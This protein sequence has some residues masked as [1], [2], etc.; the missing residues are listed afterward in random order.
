MFDQS[1]RFAVLIA[2]LAG[3]GFASAQTP[4]APTSGDG[5]TTNTA[6]QIKTLSNLVWLQYQAAGYATSGRYYKLMNDIDASPTAAW[7][8]AGTT[9]ALIEGF[10][11]IGTGMQ[12]FHGVFLGNN[13]KIS[14]L[15]INRPSENS[16]GVFGSV[17]K[18][19]RVTNLSV[20]GGSFVGLASVGPVAGYNSGYMSGCIGAAPVK[21]SGSPAGLVGCNDGTIVQCHA[22]GA[23]TG[24]DNGGGL[25]GFATPKSRILDSYATGAVNADYASGGLVGVNLGFISNCHATGAVHAGNRIG[26][27][28]GYQSGTVY[29]SYATGDVTGTNGETGGLFGVDWGST[30]T[31]CYSTGKVVGTYAVGGLIGNEYGFGRNVI[32]KCWSSGR[33]VGIGAVGGLIGVT[34]NSTIS[35]CYATGEVTGDAGSTGTG[36]LVGDNNTSSTISQC[37]ATG[38][39]SGGHGVGGL[40]GINMHNVKQCYSAGKVSGTAELGG[41]IGN[42]WMGSVTECYWDAEA[43]G[44]ATSSGGTGVIGKTTAQMRQQATF[45]NW[46]FKSMW[47]VQNAYPYLRGLTRHTLSYMASMN[48]KVGDGATTG[49]ELA[50]IV[51]AG[52]A[53]LPVK[54][55]ADRDF[56]FDSWDDGSKL[57][58]RVDSNVRGNLIVWARFK[59]TK[60]A[61]REWLVYR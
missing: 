27:L 19:A 25:V 31:L 45:A 20:I 37:Y 14:G 10:R 5:N 18:G 40:V 32:Q 22:T 8:D 53:G 4:V 49:T 30:S 46:D 12:P 61:A 47:G 2:W 21:G 56:V 43:S 9:P 26:G 3:A 55:S 7:N 57:N 58:P 29:K 48:G 24:G 13:R 1:L 23:V 28:V 16:V 50:Q 17:A 35:Q 41:L 51:N 11:P 33:V 39:T 59:S 38:K 36:G 54:A 42:S 44:R 52:S 15:V 34:L 6:Y 60:N